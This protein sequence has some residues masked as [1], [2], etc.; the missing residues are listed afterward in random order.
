MKINEVLAESRRLDESLDEANPYGG[1]QR[2]KTGIKSFLGSRSAQAKSDVGTR[3]NELYSAFVPWANRTGID[4]SQVS[5]EDLK[6][7]LTDHGL[8][9][10][11]P[12]ALKT[13]NPLNLDDQQT[14]S[15][16][17]NT[18]AQ[19]SFRAAGSVAPG[20]KGLG[21]KFGVKSETPPPPPP[22]ASPA[23]TAGQM[24]R[25]LRS[26]GVSLTRRQLNALMAALGGR[27]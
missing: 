13:T 20:S 14:S 12:P 27:P 25:A 15:Q 22:P 21:S 24:N 11:L 26:V 19:A 3:A 23:I 17:W 18:I 6:S 4:M 5:Q 1:F 8:P 16:V 2:V 9:F 7:W 10:A